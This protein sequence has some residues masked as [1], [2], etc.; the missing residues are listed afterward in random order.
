MEIKRYQ[1]LKNK[2]DNLQREVNR[3]DGALDQTLLTLKTE[4]NCATLEEG[5]KKKSEL[6][7]KARKAEKKF[8]SLLNQ[9]EEQWGD[10][11]DFDGEER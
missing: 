5:E 3:A 1:Q 8:N 2:L 7:T 9:F 4:F 10:V 11:L 6:Q